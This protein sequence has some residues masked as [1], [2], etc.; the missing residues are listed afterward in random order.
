MIKATIYLISSI[1]VLGTAII[2]P[3][4]GTLAEYF[5]EANETLV[6][7]ILTIPALT[8]ILTCF[9]AIPLSK[10]FGKKNMLLLSLFIFAVAGFA[11]AFTTDI[12][13]M[14]FWRAMLGVGIGLL[15][16]ISQTLPTDYFTGEERQITYARCGSSI[17]VGNVTFVL[18]AGILATYSWRYTFYIYLVGF[19]VLF[20]VFFTLPKH[21]TVVEK[22]EQK[23][24]HPLNPAV[25]LVAIALFLFMSSFYVMLTNIAIVVDK[26]NIGTP[27][28]VGYIV[29]TH[30]FSAFFISYN[31]VKIRKF[32][33]KYIYIFIP[34]FTGVAHILIFFATSA[35][36][37]FIAM[38]CNAIA[39]GI[40]MPLSSILVSEFSG[41][42]N[43]VKGMAVMTVSIFVGQLA[44]PFVS[45]YL[46]TFASFSGAN[47]VGSVFFTVAI[48]SFIFFILTL[49][50]TFLSSTPRGLSS[51]K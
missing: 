50:L 32:F 10:K 21:A 34:L 33:K 17:S 37:F 47:N 1:S 18:L 45:S 30:S 26:R 6:K 14:L 29:A 40:T 39:L 51:R 25:Y 20:A 11:S 24:Q 27:S 16:P 42:S 35:Y 36:M 9:F 38:A 49:L 43:I 41:K 44:S 12:Y 5:A 4:M 48:I 28:L 15:T 3:A 22:S 46:P 19:I 13:S 7:L 2:T 8:V 31:F 23:S